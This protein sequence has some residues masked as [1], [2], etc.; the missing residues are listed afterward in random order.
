MQTGHNLY[1]DK[2]IDDYLKEDRNTHDFYLQLYAQKG[3]PCLRFNCEFEEL[4]YE[5]YVQVMEENRLDEYLVEDGTV[6]EED[7][8]TTLFLSE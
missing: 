3:Q 4:S 7:S 1:A 8:E 2:N 6:A 5:E